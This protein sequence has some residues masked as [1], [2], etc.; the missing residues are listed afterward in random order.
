LRETFS[1]L[2]TGLALAITAVFLLLA[3]S[4]Q[5]IRL[6]LSV[7]LTIPAVLCGVLA[8]LL[9]SS[10]TVNVQSFTGAIM[11]I[12]IAVANS[13][14]LLTFSERSRREGKEATAAATEGASS[15]LR[16]VLMT[17][18]AM[19][20]GMIPMAA[21]IEGGAQSAPLARAV[22]GGLLLSTFATLTILPAIYS[23]FQRNVA[24]T[25]PSLNPTDPQSRY[26]EAQ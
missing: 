20:I 9:I 1:G 21:G 11:A 17:A 8:A 22:I 23:M 13:I 3:A 6:A 4:F 25:S 10:T 2:S 24:R 26:Y 15:R 5:S 14:L 19:I 18:S 16:A 12:G 7:L